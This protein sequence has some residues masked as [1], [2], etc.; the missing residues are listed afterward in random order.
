MNMRGG[1]LCLD[2]ENQV[3]AL[4]HRCVLMGK[5]LSDSNVVEEEDCEKE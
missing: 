4:A 5:E 3:I 1:D 2:A